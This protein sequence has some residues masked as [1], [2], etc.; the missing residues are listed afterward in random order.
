[1]SDFV[2]G[3]VSRISYVILAIF[4]V[5]ELVIISPLLMLIY[6]IYRSAR[7]IAP[8]MFERYELK[9]WK[10]GGRKVLL[11]VDPTSHSSINWTVRDFVI[12]E[13]DYVI[14]AHVIETTESIPTEFLT[15]D[16]SDI[17]TKNFFI[18]QY[19]SEFC[20]WLS[21]NNIRY[22][23]ILTKPYRNK[24]VADTIIHLAHKY[25]VD[26]IVA[27]ASSRTGTYLKQK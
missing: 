27:S 23:G 6:V 12:K 20:N 13:I 19:M 17:D 15:F 9:A 11:C 25:D 18:P 8:D 22:E 14:V 10:T 5:F 24:S 1:M 3:T 16:E 26:C 21:K 2:Y 7:Y 4:I